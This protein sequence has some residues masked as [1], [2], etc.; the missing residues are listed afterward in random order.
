MNIIR[1]ELSYWVTFES[2][3]KQKKQKQNTIKLIL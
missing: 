3:E 2:I 1:F